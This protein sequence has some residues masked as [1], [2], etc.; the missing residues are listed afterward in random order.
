[1]KKLIY[2]GL[3][4]MLSF[5]IV[6]LSVAEDGLETKNL[7]AAVDSGITQASPAFGESSEWSDGILL[8][9]TQTDCN[10]YGVELCRWLEDLCCDS[11]PFDPVDLFC[12][13][14]W[15]EEMCGVCYHS[16]NQ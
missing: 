3:A 8:A 9:R 14:N 10:P 11:S 2:I 5:T 12:S 15:S 7:M 16:C 4:L 1:M 13:R 6:G